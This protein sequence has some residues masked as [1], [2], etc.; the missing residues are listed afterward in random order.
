MEDISKTPYIR[1]C[2]LIMTKLFLRAS[3]AIGKII[4]TTTR[5]IKSWHMYSKS[6]CQMALISMGFTQTLMILKE[7]FPVYP[8]SKLALMLTL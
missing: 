6:I 7:V 1:S 4:I 2:I 3:N 8:S 5:V